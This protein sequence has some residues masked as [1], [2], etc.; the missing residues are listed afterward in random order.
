MDAGSKEWH[1]F[2]S[3]RFTASE[4]HKLMGERGGITTA[5][6]QTYILEKV[7]ETLTGGWHD[8]MSTIATR[9]GNDMEPE[10]VEYYQICFGVQVE[11]PDPQ[12]PEWS[13]DVSGS[14]DGLVYTDSEVYGIEIKSPYNPANHVKH[15]LIRSVDDLKSNVKEY[16]WQIVCYMLIFGLQKYEFVSFDPRFEGRNR[17]HVLEIKRCL[18]ESDIERL[19]S[20]LIEA[21]KLKNAFLK[22]IEM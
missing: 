18:I 1:L 21:S 12:C 15:M 8:D 22:R 14:P 6:A 3:G 20:T 4:C 9:W 2:R 10:A 7:A 11:K 13:D 5:T 19:K 16:Y 17:M